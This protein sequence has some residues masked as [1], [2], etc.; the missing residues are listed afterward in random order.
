MYTRPNINQIGF[1]LPASEGT[2]QS[3]LPQQ[4]QLSAAAVT[5]EATYLE[6]IDEMVHSTSRGGRELTLRNLILIFAEDSASLVVGWD[7]LRR[8][9]PKV[10][11]WLYQI[12]KLTLSVFDKSITD[13]TQTKYPK[14]YSKRRVSH[15]LFFISGVDQITARLRGYDA[16]DSVRS[17]NTE[18]L[19]N[20]ISVRGV[21]LRRTGKRDVCGDH[22]SRTQSFNLA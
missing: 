15:P 19:N 16:V 12:P 18:F 4:S 3:E 6:K 2:Q 22:R 11:E 13:L 8:Y 17:L 7:D 20:L 9:C 5:G 14:L 1:N 21:V 10:L